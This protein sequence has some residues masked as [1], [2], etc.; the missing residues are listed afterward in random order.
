MT[1]IKRFL[2]MCKSFLKIKINIVTYVTS[3]NYKW[4]LMRN[5]LMMLADFLVL[6][7]GFINGRLNFFE[8]SLN[9]QFQG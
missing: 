3:V 5:K 7:V 4:K 2:K 6:E 1:K 9:Q 8:I